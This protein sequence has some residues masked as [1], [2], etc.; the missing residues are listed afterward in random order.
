M[1]AQPYQDV[2]SEP[3]VR[4]R[5]GDLVFKL[6]ND[7]DY[8]KATIYETGG[9]QWESFWPITKPQARDLLE[10]L[11]A[12]EEGVVPPT[13]VFMG[14]GDGTMAVM[15]TKEGPEVQIVSGEGELAIILAPLAVKE[16]AGWLEIA[17]A[18]AL[19]WAPEG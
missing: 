10:C 16:I 14:G 18:N 12:Y 3:A 8:L 5:N 2:Y 11:R 1:P 6:S 19:T 9:P 15:H 17:V 7:E 13:E 4:F